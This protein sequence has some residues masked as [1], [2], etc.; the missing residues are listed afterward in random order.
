MGEAVGIIA[1]QSIGEPGTQLTL[2]TFHTGGAASLIA[3]QSQVTS[4]FDGTVQ[5]EDM[6]VITDADGQLIVLSRSGVLNVLDEDN[7]VIG[8]FEV[9]YGS[10]ILVTNGQKVT[11]G[12]MLYEWDPYNAV[13]ISEHA[14]TIR[15]KDFIENVTYRQVADELTG[16]LQTRTIDSRDR[17]KSPTIDIVGPDGH[18]IINYIIPSNAILAGAKCRRHRGRNRPGENCPRK[19]KTARYYGR[20]SARYGTLRGSLTKRSRDGFRN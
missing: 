6:K 11:K 18:I 16:N 5:Y 20:T 17:T 9:P 7:R 10:Q 14:G 4:K 8:K 2:R 15:F 3:S 12:E 1:A 19:R 13:I